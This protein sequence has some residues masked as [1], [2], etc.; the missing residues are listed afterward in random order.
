M[1]VTEVTFFGVR[2]STPCD[3]SP[4]ARYGGNTSCV[5]VD[6]TDPAEAPIVFDLGTGLRPLGEE[7]LARGGGAHTSVL[8]THL[9][10]DHI[11][12]LPFYRPLHAP[13]S[14]ID[15][16]GPRQPDGSLCEVFSRVM[17]PPYFPIRPEQL[18]G[19][20]RFHDAGDDHFPVGTAKVRSSWVRHTDPTLGFRLDW[21]GVSVAYISDHG[22][23][24]VPDD[25]DDFIPLDVLEVV[26]GVDL[27]IH[28]AQHT[29]EEY[30][31]KRHY[32]HCTVDYAVHV[33]RQAGAKGLVL[34][35]HCPTHVDDDLDRLL[36]YARDLSAATGGPDVSAAAEGRTIEL[37]SGG[38]P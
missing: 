25:P 30:Q 4:Y 6:S 31:Q 15:I 7:L 24:C 14:T 19:S 10:W 1:G 17:T 5:V 33:A 27:L 13:G 29:C 11:Q 34:F 28:D 22:P 3:G 38:S 21:H 12:G 37:V 16:Y 32:G 8:L 23:G 2:G 35:H 20:V 26:D 18:E 9:H 36:T